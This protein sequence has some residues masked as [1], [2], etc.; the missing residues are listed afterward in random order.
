MPDVYASL[1]QPAVIDLAAGWGPLR[2]VVAVS[3]A[4]PPVPTRPFYSCPSEERQL[5]EV[6][7]Q[8]LAF[9][10]MRVASEVT[11]EEEILAFTVLHFGG[12]HLSAWVSHHTDD[13]ALKE[14]GDRA[15]A[16]FLWGD[17]AE[18]IRVVGRLFGERGY[19]FGHVLRDGQRHILSRL[20]RET[21]GR[22]EP[23][24]VDG[25]E[26]CYSSARAMR[27]ADMKPSSA[28]AVPLAVMLNT[29]FRRQLE[30]PVLDLGRL[31]LLA[32]EFRPGAVEPDREVL[33]PAASRTIERLID[34]L[35]ND[36]GEGIKDEPFVL[37]ATLFDILGPLKLPLDLWK[38][39][40]VFFP[41]VSSVR[42]N[43]RR[44]AE[45]GSDEA[46]GRAGRF[47]RL[48][49]YLNIKVA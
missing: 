14:T 22:L 29:A 9:G 20:I 41:L 23:M 31:R 19:T 18:V 27:E 25:F 48:A 16:A 28:L 12:Q 5:T 24:L 44:A 39:Q 17:V 6:G 13:A 3:A 8:K 46:E 15:A 33:G 47:E 36:E 1:V 11:Q 35:T 21:V 37:A 34:D 49:G 42:P 32:D 38:S 30:Q 40:N 43:L 10:T 45:S 2:H 7:S 4:R 26:R